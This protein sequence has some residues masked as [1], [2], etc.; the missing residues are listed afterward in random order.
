[1]RMNEIQLL[2]LSEKA[3]HDN[4]LRGYLFKRSADNS[5]WQ[6]RWFVLFQNFLFY[7][8]NDSG[9]K[10]SGVI[11]LEGSYCD[12]IVQSSAGKCTNNSQVSFRE[13]ER[14]VV[15]ELLFVSLLVVRYNFFTSLLAI[16]Q[17]FEKTSRLNR[18][19]IHFV[20]INRWQVKFLT[21]CM[22]DLGTYH[23]KYRMR[24]I[25]VKM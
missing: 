18:Y 15:C 20:S 2:A 6:L 8:E 9:G 16:E 5:K 23:S 10:P 25:Y 17:F 1:M 24:G 11:F 14:N 21:F 13:S 12:K 4:G 22:T 7:F 19:R 3:L